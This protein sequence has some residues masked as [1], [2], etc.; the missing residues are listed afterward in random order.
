MDG[1]VRPIGCSSG[2]A[3]LDRVDVDVIE[4]TGK[5]FL[6]GDEVF[7][8][9][10]LPDAAF[11]FAAATGT[12]SFAGGHSARETGLDERPARC[13]VAVAVRQLPKHMQMVGHDHPSED[14]ERMTCLDPSDHVSQGIHLG[15]QQAAG[16]ISQIDREEVG[17]AR[18]PG[19]SV[20]HRLMMQHA[21][22]ALLSL[23]LGHSPE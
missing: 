9:P 7:P 18:L 10:S 6:V 21:R 23:P 3:V 22:V 19:A 20:S 15:F 16:A 1:T 4:V 14:I 13:V 11:A 17:A 8:K 2:M 12:D 5:I